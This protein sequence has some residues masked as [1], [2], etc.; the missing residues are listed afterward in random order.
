MVRNGRD[1]LRPL[2]LFLLRLVYKKRRGQSCASS[3]PRA[4]DCRRDVGMP[5]CRG[6]GAKNMEPQIDLRV[7]ELLASRLCHDLVGPVGAVGNGLELLEDEI[8][9][10]AGDAL[11]LAAQSAARAATTLQ[12]FRFAYGMAGSRLDGGV[13]ELRD[14]A[15]RFLA[16]DRVALDW[17]VDALPDGAPQDLGKV[18]LNLVLMALDSLVGGGTV[19]VAIE[20]GPGEE[21]RQLVVEAHG[22]RAELREEIALALGDDVAVGDLTPRNAHVYFTRLLA[23]RLGSDL[24]TATSDGRTVR[25]NVALPG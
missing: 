12:F 13:T 14:L 18:I 2:S 1:C 5:E 10:M 8:G 6:E 23:R 17:K 21:G 20:A 24:D 4:R 22:D 3:G 11:A 9:D 7:A 16:K 19:R 15:D 25:L